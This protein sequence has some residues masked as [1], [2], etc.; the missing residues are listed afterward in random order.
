MNAEIEYQIMNRLVDLCIC[1]VEPDILL[2]N[3]IDWH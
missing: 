2:L 1:T 3:K